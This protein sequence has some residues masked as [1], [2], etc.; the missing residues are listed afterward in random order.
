MRDHITY[1]LF[2]APFLRICRQL[3]NILDI[4]LGSVPRHENAKHCTI[5]KALLTFLAFVFDVFLFCPVF[6]RHVIVV[7]KI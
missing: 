6:E 1:L 7:S 3:A 4:R 5:I 2:D